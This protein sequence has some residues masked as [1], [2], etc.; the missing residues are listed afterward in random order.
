MRKIGPRV[1]PKT[2]VSDLHPFHEDLDLG[3]ELFADLDPGFDVF[4]DPDPG[5]KIFVDTDPGLDYFQKFVFSKLKKNSH[6]YKK[7][8]FCTYQLISQ[9]FTLLENFLKKF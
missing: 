1:S 7:D 3:F 4:A 8:D 5:L 2:R 6:R 9:T